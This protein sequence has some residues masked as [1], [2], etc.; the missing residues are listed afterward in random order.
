MLL[1]S[2]KSFFSMGCGG[3]RKSDKEHRQTADRDERL[4]LCHTCK[5]VVCKASQKLEYPNENNEN[6]AICAR[7]YQVNFNFCDYRFIETK[8]E[9]TD[10]EAAAKIQ[11]KW[12]K[13]SP[14]EH[15]WWCAI[16]MDAR[17]KA[18][19]K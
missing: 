9:W 1:Y 16:A 3:S 17:C 10:A 19:A 6:I 12:I 2:S 4:D 14:K 7:R 13:H 5:I 18:P 11:E 15:A 8:D